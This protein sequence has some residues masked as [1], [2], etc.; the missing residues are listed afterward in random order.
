MLTTVVRAPRLR[1]HER[2]TW[3]V[4][5]T[6]AFLATAASDRLYGL[7]V[8]ALSTGMRQGELFGLRW[9]DVDLGKGILTITKAVRRSILKGT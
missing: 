1:H 3:S 4:E 8:L 7:Y 9:R 6:K 5:E 2:H